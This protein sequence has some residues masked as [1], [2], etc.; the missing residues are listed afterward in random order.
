M[1]RDEDQY[2][3]GRG[4]YYTGVPYSEVGRHPDWCE[5]YRDAE[6]DDGGDWMY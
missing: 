4:A 2:A 1:E 3:E 5:G 6:E